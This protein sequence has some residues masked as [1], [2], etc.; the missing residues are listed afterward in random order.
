[1][2]NYKTYKKEK[3]IYFFASIFAFLAPMIVAI[4]SFFP[5]FDYNVPSKVAFGGVLVLLHTSV[6]AAG[7]WGSI[8]AHYPMLS[9]L[10]FVVIIL[11][12]L[13]QIDFFQKYVNALV[14]IEGI[15]ACGMIASA[16][17]WGKYRK[18]STKATSMDAV[19]GSGLLKNYE[20]KK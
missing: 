1:M 10:P 8:R 13:F 18:Y 16:V 15:I 19:V 14:I 17:F 2:A 7:V 5:F 20:E 11:Y 6:F 9:P 4:A 12:T 3:W